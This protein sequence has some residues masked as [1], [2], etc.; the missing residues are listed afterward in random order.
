MLVKIKTINSQAGIFRFLDECDEK[1][2]GYVARKQVWHIPS[3]YAYSPVKRVLAW[4]GKTDG[5]HW[6]KKIV[7]FETR[8]RHYEVFEIPDDFQVF[9]TDEEAEEFNFRKEIEA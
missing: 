8:H 7:W 5:L 6:K 9:S 1:E 4:N 2:V 3:P